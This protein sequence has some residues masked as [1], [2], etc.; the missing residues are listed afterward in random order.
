MHLQFINTGIFTPGYI[1][2][3]Q[4]LVDEFVLLLE[5]KF[6]ERHDLEYYSNNLHI[7]LKRLNRL[8]L[9][10]HHKTVYQL[11]QERLHQE[12]K[13]LLTHTT[14]SAKEIAFELRVCDAAYFSK[15]FKKIAGM[16]PVEYRRNNRY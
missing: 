9:H 16:S 12:A 14:L 2:Q 8:L 10:Y 6:K 7:S 5:A 11:L 4:L 13:L 3:D 15:C 1:P